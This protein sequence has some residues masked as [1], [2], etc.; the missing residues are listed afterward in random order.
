VGISGASQDGAPVSRLWRIQVR[1]GVRVLGRI[2]GPGRGGE[3][4][5]A[6]VGAGAAPG[7]PEPDWGRDA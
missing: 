7:Q 2:D 4:A 1:A 5:D 6:F 3:G